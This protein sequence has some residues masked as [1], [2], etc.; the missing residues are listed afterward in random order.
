[1]SPK[2][3]GFEEA[4]NRDGFAPR[5]FKNRIVDRDILVKNG[6]DPDQ[7]IWK[8]R[9]VSPTKMCLTFTLSKRRAS[10]LESH[11][12]WQ[13][14]LRLPGHAPARKPVFRAASMQAA[15]Y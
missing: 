6:I 14:C 8:I 1:M 3:G 12:S 10:Y 15:T 2:V 11:V 9:H 5:K 7:F 13:P 4:W